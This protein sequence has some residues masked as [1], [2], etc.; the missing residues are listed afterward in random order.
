MFE[1]IRIVLLKTSHPGNIGSVARAMKNM[2]FENLYLVKPHH[3][4]SPEA[5]AL[6]G[7]AK[8]V[9]EKAKKVE[10][11]EEALQGCHLVLG[12]SSRV[13][14]IS[15]PI[16]EMREAVDK[17]T[18][19]LLENSKLQIAFLLGQEQSGLS[20]EELEKCHYQVNIAA[21]PAYASLN[22]AQAVQIL[23]YELRKAFLNHAN[24]LPVVL[25]SEITTTE[26]MEGFYVHLEAVL[27][28]IQFLDPAQSPLLMTRLRRLFSRA[29][30]DKIE[31]NV[32]RGML[33]AIQKRYR[34]ECSS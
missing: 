6:A 15:W 1:N 10:S 5:T 8:D 31:L 33:T 23:T 32:L 34:K 30:P 12:L 28:D 27:R 7:G 4:P 11:L 14:K 26:E 16:L 13:R 29:G 18:Q 25:E 21:N 22:L 19:H 20:N 2:G 3:F 9:L 24:S 17:V